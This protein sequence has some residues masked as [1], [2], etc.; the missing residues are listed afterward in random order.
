MNFFQA[1]ILA[2]LFLPSPASGRLGIRVFLVCGN[3]I[4][5]WQP[6]YSVFGHD[7]ATIEVTKNSQASRGASW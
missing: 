2:E 1:R 3:T 7:E 5:F 4:T 6:V